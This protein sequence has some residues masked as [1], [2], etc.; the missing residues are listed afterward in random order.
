MGSNGA[1]LRAL[2]AA[3]I[4]GYYDGLSVHF[5]NLVLA[6]LRYIH[7]VQLQNGDHTPLWLNEFGWS[8]CWPRQRVQQEQGCVTKQV[9]AANLAN[10]FR[11]T[12]THPV[13]GGGDRCTSYRA[14][15]AKTSACSAKQARAS[16]RSRRCAACSSRPSASRAR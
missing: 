10:V 4:K 9:Q 6:S 1:F 12:R 11:S 13:G 16:R 3:G 8:S 14:R 5:Y 15:A 7:E 2:Y